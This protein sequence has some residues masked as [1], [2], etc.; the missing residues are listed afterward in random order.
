MKKA[1]SLLLV[2]V[3]VLLTVS[4]MAETAEDDK[5]FTITLTSNPTTGYDW[6]YVASDD[7]ITVEQEYLT[8]ADI[9]KLAGIQPT[10][11]PLSGEGGLTVFTI[12]GVKPGTAVIALEYAQ[13][14]D[15]NSTEAG[16]TYTLAVNDDLSVVCV[17]S[18]FGM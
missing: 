5:C 1:F 15:E 12:K 9:D 7:F 17:A 3:M 2:L 10:A 8:S 16:L 14:W 11:E 4:A 18:T 13:S 6:Q